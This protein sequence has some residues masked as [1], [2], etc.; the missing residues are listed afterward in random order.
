MIMYGG[1]PP[2]KHVV[3]GTRQ[4]ADTQIA[5][6]SVSK[7]MPRAHDA[8]HRCP[9]MDPALG[10]TPNRSICFDLLHTLYLGPMQSWCRHVIWVLLLGGIWGILETTISEQVITGILRLRSEL[11]SWYKERAKLFPMENLTRVAD[12]TP[13]MV[14][15]AAE[16][17]IKTKAMETFGMLLFLID[18]LVKYAGTI[19]DD[20]G[21]F[22]EA[23]RMLVR[24]V[25]IVRGSPV[26]MSVSAIQEPSL[27]TPPSF[28][29]PRSLSKKATEGKHIVIFCLFSHIYIYI[30]IILYIQYKQTDL[31][32]NCSQDSFK[33]AQCYTN[34][35]M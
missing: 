6:N 22:A 11:F 31:A 16:P 25:E 19:G 1:Q 20:A 28:P 7:K 9:L 3:S 30:Y 12:L 5:N 26:N 35:K 15:T 24:Y 32:P 10:I 13:K 18:M 17:K 2:Y 8:P 29:S 21:R 4:P 33:F 14:G 23:G 34:P 27:T